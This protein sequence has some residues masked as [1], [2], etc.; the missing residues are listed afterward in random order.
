MEFCP[1]QHAERSEK[2]GVWGRIPQE[3]R[4]G[5]W[6]G[7]EGLLVGHRT[8]WGILPQTP[9][10]SLRSA[11]CR[12]LSRNHQINQLHSSDGVLPYDST[13]EA[14]GPAGRSSDF[15]GDPPPD[16]RFSLRSARCRG[17]S[18]IH[19]IN[20]LR[21]S[22]GALPTKARRAKRENGGLGEDPPGSPMTN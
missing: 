18:K 17:L 21:S 1:R 15:L 3:V 2:T 22:D 19:Q 12:R 7:P 5:V 8:S 9:V 13:S 20:Q 16:P 4:F 14:R 6:A 10:F 11:R